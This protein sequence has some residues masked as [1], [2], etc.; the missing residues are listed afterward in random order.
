[1]DTLYLVDQC[2]RGDTSAIEALVSAHHAEIYRLA[3]SILDDPYEADEAAQDTFIAALRGMQSYRAESSLRTWLFTIAVNVCRERL[4]RRK[5]RASLLER[6]SHRLLRQPAR[7][8]SGPEE[9]MM[10]IEEAAT[11]HDAVQRLDQSLRLPILLRYAHDMQVT[12]IARIL[13]VSRR[14]VHTRLKQA[15]LRLQAALVETSELP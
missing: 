4:R 11:L 10:Q 6:L 2:R 14:T 1:M 8:T 15:H 13:G 5:S 3:L 7:S 9:S 12:E